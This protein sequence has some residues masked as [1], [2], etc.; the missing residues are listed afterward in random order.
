LKRAA[1]GG[2][3]TL[4]QAP[5]PVLALLTDLRAALL[6]VHAGKDLRIEIDAAPDPGFLGDSGDILELLGNVVDNACKWCRSRVLVSARID[7]DRALPRRLS[8]VVQDDGPG[9]PPELRA[10]VIERGVRADEHVPGHGLGLAMVRETVALYGGQF[11]IDSSD[12]LGGA[13]V[14]L[15]LPG[16]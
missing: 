3:A 4:G 8:I 12:A 10:R 11:L 5:V 15:R 13:R 2:G 1:A 14:E 6:K 7:P 16:R 9:I